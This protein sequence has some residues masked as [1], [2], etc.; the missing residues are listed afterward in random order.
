MYGNLLRNY[1]DV[2]EDLGLARKRCDELAASNAVAVA[3]LEQAQVSL[4]CLIARRF[5]PGKYL[6][7][8]Y[9]SRVKDM[10]ERTFLHFGSTS[11]SN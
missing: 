8:L 2:K 6:Y 3:K 1:E 4:S 9:R 5:F 7:L 11:L 10:N